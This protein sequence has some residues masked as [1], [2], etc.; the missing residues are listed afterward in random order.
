MP[1]AT[2]R[3]A[4]GTTFCTTPMMTPKVVPESASP[5]SRP[6]ENSRCIGV[7]EN[8]MSTRPEHVARRSRPSTRPAP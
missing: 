7:L 1:S 3:F 4:G 6:A 8:A 2:L 5:I